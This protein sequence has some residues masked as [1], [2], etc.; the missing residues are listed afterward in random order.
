VEGRP[1]A[2]AALLLR[3][4]TSINTSGRSNE[5]LYVVDGV[6]LTGGTQDI[7]GL[8]IDEIEV[9]KGAAGAA[10]YG[11]RAANGVVSITTLRG[12]NIPE[13]DTRLVL[14][15]E[16][17]RNQLARRI[18]T[19]QFHPYRV[20][21]D[22]QYTDS[23]GEVV[24]REERDVDWVI[25]STLV[26]TDEDGIPDEWV[27]HQYV[28]RDNIYGDPIYDQLDLFFDPGTVTTTS[29]DVSH[30]TAATNFLAAA[31]RTTETGIVDGIDG[32]RRVGAR[33][34]VDHRISRTADLHASAA[35][36]R[37]MSDEPAAHTVNPF[38][39]LSSMPP[40]AKLDTLFSPPRDEND[41]LT[42][43]PG[44]LTDNVLYIIH[45]L[46][47]Q[48]HRSRILG[49]FSGSW[50]PF[51]LLELKSDLSFDRVDRNRTEFFPRGWRIIPGRQEGGVLDKR[52]SFS[53]ALNGSITATLASSFGRLHWSATGRY[54]VERQSA[55]LAQA[56]AEDF[57]AADVR[58]FDLGNPDR[59]EVSGSSSEVNSLGYFVGTQLDYA[60]RYIANLLLR[61]DGSSLFGADQ[62]WH[63]YYRMSAA[64][65]ISQE[66]FW[67]FAFIDQFKVRYSRGTAGGRPRFDAQF[68]T[69]VPSGGT[70]RRTHLGNRALRPEYATE[71]EFGLDL[72]ALGKISLSVVHARTTTEDQILRA[73]L[74]SYTGF[75]SQWQNVG[76]L[77]SVTWEG[78]LQAQLLE[79]PDVNWSVNL[80]Y[81][82]T[83]T[84]IAELFIPS[85]MDWPTFVR[86]GEQ[87]N[88][89]WGIR[90]ATTCDEVL[91]ASGFGAAC[92]A[93]DV[94]DDSYLVP[95]GV[96]NTFTDGIT[97]KL[98][99][100]SITIDDS[101]YKWG[102]PV[103]SHEVRV[104]RLL[105]GSLRTD[106]TTLRRI[107]SSAPA[108]SVGFGSSFR[109]KQLSIYGLLDAQVGAKLYNDLRHR[110]AG[111]GGP[112]QAGKPEELKKPWQYY[113]HL[114]AFFDF[115][116]E[117]AEDATFARLREI[118]VS[119]TF[120]PDVL[121]QVLGGVIKRITVAAIGR[122]LFT[123][124]RYSGYDPEAS[125]CS[126]DL[127]GPG[128]F[129]GA[130]PWCD[131]TAGVLDGWTYPSYRTF[132]ASVALEF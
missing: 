111:R 26:D 41:F 97:K 90:W 15:T 89:I 125:V 123:W 49:S 113:G 73:P 9:V 101:T 103:R 92:D 77:K 119:Y 45:N 110:E 47:V 68:E 3:G 126:A 60:D 108:Y 6:I 43:I 40:D 109:F 56:R 51:S 33:M 114:Y 22:G 63:T 27:T 21:E 96:G 75:R 80:V 100:S 120:G 107:G 39:T 104:E 10:L 54:L 82:R 13:G 118:S 32:Y 95:V 70:L 48:D 121:D 84:S 94:N 57:F 46:D 76:T 122:N 52:S 91:T 130:G 29:L 112:D 128:I 106:T 88:D 64:Y 65:R 36:T 86:E 11:S 81:D 93:F 16:I 44:T 34:N 35:Y 66:P 116:S 1:G 5:P 17:G 69:F 23:A 19:S 99:G 131:A 98:Y 55:E 105:D 24:T 102:Y 38:R 25:D 37:S 115:N 72:L 71:D 61:R 124:T 62:R 53:E 59:A 129:Y 83:R 79:A 85:Y 12:A 74:Q 132:T 58:D 28:L 14:R 2:P 87:L 42:P 50:R 117:F 127:D 18:A 20:N 31:H 78:T 7:D 8:H 67:P 4:A 30:R